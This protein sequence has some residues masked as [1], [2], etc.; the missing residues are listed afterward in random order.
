MSTQ[1]DQ[2]ERVEFYSSRA[3]ANHILLNGV[4]RS[5]HAFRAMVA[6]GSALDLTSEK[7]LRLIANLGAV[8]FLNHPQQINILDKS[9][10]KIIVSIIK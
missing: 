2:D 10:G 9:N 6:S 7:G 5:G 3:V 4:P 8:S 1:K